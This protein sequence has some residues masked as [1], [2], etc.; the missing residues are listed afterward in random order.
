MSV[1]QRFW[2]LPRRLLICLVRFVRAGQPRGAPV[3]GYNTAL[4]LLP[5]RV[6]ED[7]IS[8]LASTLAATNGSC[9]TSVDIAVAVSSV[10]GELP[11]RND[12]DRVSQRLLEDGWV[13]VAAPHQSL[14]LAVITPQVGWPLEMG[15][16][17][18][19]TGQGRNPTA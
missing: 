6:T 3:T 7:E 4:A 11:A 8:V 10:T 9:L 15:T 19:C 13:I 18:G 17:L 5:R 16:E 2:G 1:W 12:V 14:G